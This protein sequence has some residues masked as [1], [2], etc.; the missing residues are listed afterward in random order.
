MIQKDA[1]DDDHGTEPGERR[2]RVAEQ[3]D[4]EPDEEGAFRSISH[5]NDKEGKKIIDFRT[6]SS[7]RNLKKGPIESA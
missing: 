6:S 7:G 3:D 1:E 4:R 5:A 2:H